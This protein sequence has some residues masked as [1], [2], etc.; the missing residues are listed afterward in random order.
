ML[1]DKES[2]LKF[3]LGGYIH[4]SKKDYQFFYNVLTIVKN[5]NQI[6]SNQDKLFNKLLYKYQRQLTK[7][8]KVVEELVTLCWKCNLVETSIDYTKAYLRVVGDNL[9]IKTPYNTKFINDFRKIDFN[10]FEWDKPN[11]QYVAPKG[12][13]ALKIGYNYLKKHFENLVVDDA[14]QENINY[15]IQLSNSIWDPTLTY[16]NGNYFI[17]GLNESLYNSIKD[18]ML[19]D[20]PKTLFELSKFGVNISESIINDDPLKKFASSY[21]FELDIEQIHTLAKWLVTLGVS[22]V[23]TSRELV[24]NKKISNEVRDVFEAHN[25]SYTS[26]SSSEKLPD[27]V[28]INSRAYNYFMISESSAFN[29][30]KVITVKNSRPIVIK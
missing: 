11:K 23:C 18:I 15:V 10:P 19:N 13:Y 24:F 8:G 14:L 30:N 3:L 9:V 17:A 7:E 28:L 16:V 6:T 26:V 4:L 2:L 22:T 5:S 25:I 27:M 1:T 12:S 21:F 20:D 29:F